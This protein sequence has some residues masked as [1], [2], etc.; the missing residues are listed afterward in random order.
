MKNKTNLFRDK[1]RVFH[2]AAEKCISERLKNLSNIEY[3]TS[4]IDPLKKADITMD[5]TNIPWNSSSVDVIICNHVLE[6]VLDD[7]RAMGRVVQ[8]AKTWWMGN[9][10]CTF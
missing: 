6:H 10:R 7:I 3:I 2:F 4:D 1:L 9:I 5:I 8:S